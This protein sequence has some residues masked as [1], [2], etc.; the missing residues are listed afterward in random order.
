M[1]KIKDAHISS[2]ETNREILLTLYDNAISMRDIALFTQAYAYGEGLQDA[3]DAFLSS[4]SEIIQEIMEIKAE[5][6]SEV[7]KHGKN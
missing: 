7:M 3:Y 4:E 5:Q 1:S 6:F 2:L